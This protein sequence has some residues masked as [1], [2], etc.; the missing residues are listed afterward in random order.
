[1][2][3]L[4]VTSR[5]DPSACGEGFASV[6]NLGNES[7]YEAICQVLTMVTCAAF[8]RIAS[9]PNGIQKLHSLS[10]IWDTKAPPGHRDASYTPTIPQDSNQKAHKNTELSVFLFCDQIIS[11]LAGENQQSNT[12]LLI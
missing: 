5:S 8:L 3:E 2:L 9:I 7:I 11:F 6:G 12:D 4:C 1:M 10:K